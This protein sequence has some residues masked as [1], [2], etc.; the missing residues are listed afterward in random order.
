MDPEEVRQK[1]LEEVVSS[2]ALRD[3]CS[4]SEWPAYDRIHVMILIGVIAQ[5]DEIMRQLLNCGL[6]Q[7]QTLALAA[8]SFNCLLFHLNVVALGVV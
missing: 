3:G 1:L 5:Q 4:M 8:Q 2:C 7:S 6:S